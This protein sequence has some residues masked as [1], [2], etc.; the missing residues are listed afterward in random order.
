MFLRVLIKIIHVYMN[1]KGR[2]MFNH[3]QITAVF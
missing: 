2:I 3:I 1:F